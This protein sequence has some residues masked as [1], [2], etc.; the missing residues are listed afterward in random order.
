MRG[1]PRNHV[2]E[3]SAEGATVRA[4]RRDEP[5]GFQPR[6]D[7]AAVSLARRMAQAR[8]RWYSLAGTLLTSPPT[9]ES[10]EQMLGRDFRQ[11]A[12]EWAG[13]DS[14]A[15]LDQ[16]A[17]QA[18]SPDALCEAFD[19]LFTVPGPKYLTPYE[20]VFRD[21][22]VLEDGREVRGLT[23]GPSTDEVMRYYGLAGAEISDRYDELPDHVGLE[24]EFMRLLCERE[25][26][27]LNR[28]DVAL[29]RRIRETQAGFLNRHLAAWS[30]DLVARARERLAHPFYTCLLALLRDFADAD[31]RY[32][33]SLCSTEIEEAGHGAV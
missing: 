13:A 32:L 19:E 33:Q 3:Q 28:G 2:Q 27:A 11:A 18:D 16:W 26:E 7:V 25:E 22:R 5:P 24:V 8:A 4:M 14:L 12:A 9:R 6:Q 17:A 30:P 29:A 31:L 20:S 15:M 10:V 23:F 1:T 21:S